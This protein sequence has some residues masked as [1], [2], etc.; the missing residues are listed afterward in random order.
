M[1]VSA[2]GYHENRLELSVYFDLCR[3]ADFANGCC[4]Q[5]VPC[6][7]SYLCQLLL[8]A[9]EKDIAKETEVSNG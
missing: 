4:L 6:S 1:I 9:C 5:S 2:K 7:G 3:S 8:E